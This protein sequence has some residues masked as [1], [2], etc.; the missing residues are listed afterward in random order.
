MEL[1]HSPGRISDDYHAINVERTLK[2][3]RRMVS[4][5]EYALNQV[6]FRSSPW[7][8][9]AKPFSSC[10]MTLSTYSFQTPSGPLKHLLTRR[11]RP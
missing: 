10:A 7:I 6:R 8:R 5:H 4:E 1:R 2:E 11:R 3:L 9:L